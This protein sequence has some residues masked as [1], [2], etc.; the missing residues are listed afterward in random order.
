[1]K[2]PLDRFRQM[3]L[4]SVMV[5]LDL[6]MPIHFLGD[7]QHKY[8]QAMSLPELLFNPPVHANTWNYFVTDTPNLFLGAG[9]PG[10]F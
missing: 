7:R 1:M 6:L 8:C 10:Y 5:A 3:V 9:C 4:N 2:L